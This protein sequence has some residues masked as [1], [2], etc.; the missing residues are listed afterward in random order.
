MSD[1]TFTLTILIPITVIFLSLDYLRLINKKMKMIYDYFFSYV[2]RNEES[3]KITGASY[4]FLSSTIIILFFSKEIAICS[5]LI[6][7]ISDTLA[8]LVGRRYG[9]IK[10]N[11]KTLEGSLVFFASSV[12]IV[13]IMNLNLLIGITSALITTYVEYAKPGNI[14][15]NLSVPLSFSISYFLFFMLLSALNLININ[16]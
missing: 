16:L 11:N 9:V 6:M 4:V 14:D 13:L 15:D 10:L 5:L 2:T 1:R 7:S 12:L 8:A 3:E